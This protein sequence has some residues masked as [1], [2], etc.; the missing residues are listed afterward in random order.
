MIGS[1]RIGRLVL[2]ALVAVGTLGALG[3]SDAKKDNAEVT[4]DAVGFDFTGDAANVNGKAI[5]ASELSALLDGFREA[6][7]AVKTVFGVDEVDQE[8]TSQP[9]PVVVANLL[10][11]AVLT[12]LI[13]DEVAKRKLTVSDTNMSLAT[14]NLDGQFGDSLTSAP[15]LRDE[16]VRRYA[17]YITLDRDLTPP[18]PDDAAIRAAYDKD[19]GKW[20]TACGRHILVATEQEAKAAQAELAGGKPFAEVATARSTDT[21]SAAQGGDLG[22]QAPGVFVEEFEQA[23]WK[24]PLNQVQGPVKT[25]FGFHLIEVTSRKQ[26]SFEEAREDLLTELRPQAFDPLGQWLQSAVAAATVAVD[27][28]FG[29][30]NAAAGQVDPVGVSTEGLKMG[31]GEISTTVAS[32]STASSTTPK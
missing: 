9:Q 27:G 10:S 18:A 7:G 11:T 17:V 5:P 16:L 30:W 6:P 28:R 22:C 4:A 14:T 3:C 25:Q 23:M 13:E 15:A 8:G 26:R 32:K 2:A 19:P 1:R 31:S 12:R 21:G 29:S 24:G 20:Q